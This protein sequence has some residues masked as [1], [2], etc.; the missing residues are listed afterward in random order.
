MSVKTIID[1]RRLR[2]SARCV[3]IVEEGGQLTAV[4]DRERWPAMSRSLHLD[5]EI[6]T[7][8]TRTPAAGLQ[9]PRDHMTVARAAGLGFNYATLS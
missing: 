1:L 9:C 6:G 8:T 4:L 2:G 7:P 3:Q 5:E